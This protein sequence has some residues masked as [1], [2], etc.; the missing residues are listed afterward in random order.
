MSVFTFK[1]FSVQQGTDVHPVGTDSMVL[2]AICNTNGTVETALDIGTG[3]GVLSLMLAQQF[4][5]A[6][7]SA[8]DTDENSV[9]LAQLNFLNSPWSERLIAIQS[10]LNTFA[11]P[12]KFDLIISNPPYFDETYLSPDQHRNRQR[13]SESMPINELIEQVEKLLSPKGSFWFIAPF[14][15]KLEIE[16]LIQERTFYIEQEIILEGKPKTPVRIIFSISMDATIQ[17]QRHVFTIRNNDGTY[18]EE[19]KALTKDFHNRAL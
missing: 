15:R 14:R 17:K 3:T 18:T 1:H 16:E 13:N 8:I 10:P 11:V 7:I 2:G 19:Y 4:P 9:K 5:S 12:Q 6:T